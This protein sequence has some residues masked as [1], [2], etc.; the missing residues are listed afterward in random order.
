[1]NTR[2]QSTRTGTPRREAPGAPGLVEETRQPDQD[3]GVPAG[4]L[5]NLTHRVQSPERLQHARQKPATALP[6]NEAEGKRFPHLMPVTE[7]TL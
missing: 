3:S 6:W 4:L 1:M 5:G 7:A 2:E